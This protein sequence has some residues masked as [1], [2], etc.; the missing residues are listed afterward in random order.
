MRK[1]L[2]IAGLLL[3]T[4]FVPGTAAQAEPMLGCSCVKLGAEPVCTATVLD[5][6]TK[7]GGVCLA[8][9]TYEPP[10][11]AKKGKRK[12]KSM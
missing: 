6:N 11:M 8:A 1:Y 2:V 10:K 5:C 9:C 4:A 3:G 7:V 12:K